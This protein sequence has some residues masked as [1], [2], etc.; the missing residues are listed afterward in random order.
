[1][2][3][4]SDLWTKYGITPTEYDDMLARQGRGCAICTRV[5]GTGQPRLAVDHDHVTGIVRGLLCARCNH[6]LLGIFGDDP[7][8]YMRAE[9]YLNDPPATQTLT[10]DHRIPDSPPPEVFL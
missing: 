10:A 3:W 7:Q 1:M 4:A 2:T 9:E 6:D 8:F 5:P